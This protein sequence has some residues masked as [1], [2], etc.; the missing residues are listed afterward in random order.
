MTAAERLA[1]HEARRAPYRAV[2][3]GELFA[4]HGI[5]PEEA[6]QRIRLEPRR[7][8]PCAAHRRPD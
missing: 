5:T 4:A 7:R 8:C 3:E 1:R 6:L 2:S